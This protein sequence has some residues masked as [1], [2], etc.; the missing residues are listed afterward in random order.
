MAEK[1]MTY[2]QALEV[3]L[4]GGEITEEVRER[5]EALQVSVSK[6]ASP[7]SKSAVAKAKAQTEI[8]ER[9][10]SAMTDIGK[11][12]TATDV[13]LAIGESTSK[14]TAYLTMLVKEEKVVKTSDKKKS[15]YS[16]PK[17]E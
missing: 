2:A 10:L 3:V 7:D 15:Y 8:K 6:K 9:I 5:L 12:A 1:K 16:L 4:G 17:A 11:S 14:A 13:A